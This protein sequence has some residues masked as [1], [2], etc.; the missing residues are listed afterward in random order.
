MSVQ[1]IVS[2]FLNGKPLTTEGPAST[3]VVDESQVVRAD[4]SSESEALE[5]YGM[6]AKSN[7]STEEDMLPGSGDTLADSEKAANAKAQGKSQTPDKEV[8]T[9]TDDKGRRQVEIDYSNR[10]A[11]KKAFQ[12]Q[13]GARKWQAERDKALETVKGKDSELAQ[14]KQDWSMLD[15]AFQKGPEHLFDLLQGQGSF[16]KLLNK[17]TEKQEFL[18]NASPREIAELETRERAE[19]QTR[20][21]EKLRKDNED[22]KKQMM[23]E[24]E[25]TEEKALESKVHPIFDKY[26]FADKLGSAEDEHLFDSLLWSQALQRLEPYEEKGVAITQELIDKEF[27][28]VATSIRNRINVQAEKKATKV[29]EQKKREATENVQAKVKSGY[30]TGGTAQEA[31][32]LMQ[33]GDLTSLLKGWG[34]YGSL[35]NGGKK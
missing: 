21:L 11:I 9:I 22:F 3:G 20:E 15:Q 33:K 16:E 31:R 8:I 18:K 17:H 4:A 5:D 29:V 35:F 7:D 6:D 24:R 10:E 30:K 26:R 13:H 25:Q 28:A 34:K 1:N 32:E 12:F 19:T 2:Q 27:K 14:I 23:S